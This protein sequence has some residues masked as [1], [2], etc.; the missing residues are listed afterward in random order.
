MTTFALI[1]A[2]L[3]S[4]YEVTA[5]N[6]MNTGTDTSAVIQLLQRRFPS[7]TPFVIL[8]IAPTSSHDTFTYSV[9]NGML[10]VTASNNIALA[11]GIY[12]YLKA[13]QNVIFT[14][15]EDDTGVS[16]ASIVVPFKTNIPNVTKQTPYTY[17]YA[18][19]VCT[20]GYTG[21]WWDWP[22]WQ[23]ELDWMAFHGINLPLAF[24]GQEY[25]WAQVWTT[26]GATEDDL[27]QWLSGPAFLPW[28]RMG[29]MAQWLGPLSA[30]YRKSQY[31]MQLKILTQMRL[32]GMTPVLP[33]FG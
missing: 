19:N 28:Q 17:R 21:T 8:N 18:W 22:R 14:W 3:V 26:L 29:N 15:G 30:T 7:I 9:Q 25:V 32:F 27:Q 16:N 20:Y 13:H 12:Q 23:W 11:S 2:L 1:L 5:H 4:G 6:M 24:V 10:T 31:N 33:C